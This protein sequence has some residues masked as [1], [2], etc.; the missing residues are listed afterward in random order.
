MEIVCRQCNATGCLNT[1][2]RNNRLGEGVKVGGV[3]RQGNEG[4]GVRFAKDGE[5]GERE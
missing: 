5:D 4:D 3:R 2:L 1:R